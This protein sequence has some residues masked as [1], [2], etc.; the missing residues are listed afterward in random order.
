MSRTGNR[1][2]SRTWLR[3]LVLLLALWVPGVHAQA[4]AAPALG[5][6]AE[7]FEH[8]GT[9]VLDPLVRPP[10][11]VVHRADVPER[12]APLADPAPARPAAPRCPAAP[13]V[14]YAPS[15]LRTVVLRC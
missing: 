8:D 6:P 4:Q 9:D 3:V 13:R 1:P 12:P 15:L 7:T 5:V 11:R 10:A 14:P 2:R